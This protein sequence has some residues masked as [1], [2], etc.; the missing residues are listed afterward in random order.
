[1]LIGKPNRIAKVGLKLCVDHQKFKSY[2]RLC[3]LT[4]RE[5]ELAWELLG[6]LNLW[7]WGSKSV[8]YAETDTPQVSEAVGPLGSCCHLL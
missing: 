1:M 6:N 4:N 7:L 2:V 5:A 8:R 3:H